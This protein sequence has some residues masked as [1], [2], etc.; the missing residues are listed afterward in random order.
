MQYLLTQEEMSKLS[1]EIGDKE[2]SHEKSSFNQEMDEVFRQATL[3]IRHVPSD[4]TM[5]EQFTMSIMTKDIPPKLLTYI[6]TMV[7]ARN[8]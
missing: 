7:T 6:K 8:R 2:D 5:S 4:M 1:K 3:D